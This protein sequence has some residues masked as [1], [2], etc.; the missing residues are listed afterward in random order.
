MSK[1]HS[2]RKGDQPMSFQIDTHHSEIT[3]KVGHLMISSV[4]GAFTDFTGTVEVAE[5]NPANSE[6]NVEIDAASINT[7]DGMGEGERKAPDF[8]VVADYATIILKSTSM[9]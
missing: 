7:R 3:F 8:L 6:A 1:Y 2:L 4:S 5:S 9:H